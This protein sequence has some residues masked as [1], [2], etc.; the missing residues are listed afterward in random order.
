MLVIMHYRIGFTKDTFK[1]VVKNKPCMKFCFILTELFFSSL[2]ETPDA[3]V[4]FFSL[5]AQVLNCL[6]AMSDPLYDTKP[7]LSSH[8]LMNK[9]MFSKG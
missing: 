4:V 2:N 9:C 1:T 5:F 7:L 6:R 8:A 3:L